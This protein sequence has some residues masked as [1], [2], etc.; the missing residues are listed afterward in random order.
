MITRQELLEAVRILRQHF[1]E[2]QQQFAARLNTAV[3]TVARWETSRPPSGAA[4]RQLCTLAHTERIPTCERVF[5][6]AMI[7]NVEAP[8]DSRNRLDFLFHNSREQAF[9]LALVTMLRDP[10]RYSEAL[11]S[12]EPVLRQCVDNFKNTFD[13]ENVDDRLARAV[14]GLFEKGDP[15]DRI[16]EQV[17]LGADVIQKILAMRM[18]DLIPPLRKVAFARHHSASSKKTG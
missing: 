1:D 18:F 4:L 2:T 13:S 16:T 10:G 9:A 3:I 14:V 12:V 15:P 8:P 6:E 11:A 5:Q 17:G 7:G